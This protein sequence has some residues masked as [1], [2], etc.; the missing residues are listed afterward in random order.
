MRRR[1]DELTSFAFAGDLTPSQITASQDDYNPTG[2]A[3]AVVLRLDSDASRNITGLAG[4]RDGR[5][6]IIDNIGANNIVLKDADTGSSA[7]NRFALTSDITITPD[8]MVLLK[9]DGTTQ[10]WRG[11]IGGVGYVS[12]NSANKATD[13]ST[14]NNTLYPSVQAVKSYVDT[15]AAGI[16]WK[17][18]VKV[19]T[20]VGGALASDFENGDTVDGV[21]LATG[22]R[23][24]IKNQV[25]STDENGIYT[26]NA[27]GAPTRATDADS[28]SELVS[29]AVFVEQGTVNADKA[30]VCTNDSITLGVTG[31]DFVSFAFAI[32]AIFTPYTNANDVFRCDSPGG[33]SL[34]TGTISGTP[35]GTS[36]TVS[37]PASGTEAVLVPTST[38]QLGKMRLY[39]LTRGNY[40]LIQNYNTGTNV[41]TLVSTVPGDW[42][43]GD[44]LSVVSLTVS[45]G[46]VN[47]VDIEITDATLL[48]KSALHC[49]ITI[50]SAT[51]AGNSF[52]FHPTETFGA[53]KI[54]P[55]N[56]VEASIADGYAANLKLTSNLLTIGWA[57]TPAFVRLRIFGYYN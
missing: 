54:L 23:I 22:D 46:G 16:K 34:W 7:A 21:V 5:I 13:F 2:L 49:L 53:S 48:G 26:V 41:V 17:N 35:S 30:F 57:G 11:L 37:A 36:V 29:A 25:G 15:L 18:S 19:A 32:G 43:N 51:I 27:S 44:S 28:G 50:Q 20:T 56:V 47:W 4:G 14:V 52:A 12:E 38:S 9:Y 33:P 45:G 8:S 40:A 6:I 3:S 1:D 42:A 55:K 24:L 10:R 39:N 31:I